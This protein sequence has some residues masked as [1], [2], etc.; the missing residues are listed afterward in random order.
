MKK[1]LAIFAVAAFMFAACGN[2]PKEEEVAA[3]EVAVEEVAEVAEETE[4][5]AEVA[6]EG[7]EVAAEETVAE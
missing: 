7:A 2:Q 6:E 3:E 1:L 5:V 4:E